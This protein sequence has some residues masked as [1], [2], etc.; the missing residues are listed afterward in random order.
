MPAV[1]QALFVDGVPRGFIGRRYS[2]DPELSVVERPGSTAM[3]RFGSAGLGD[4]I[5]IDLDTGHVIE[6]VNARVPVEVFVNST[7]QQ[8]SRTVESMIDRFPYYDSD[9]DGDELDAVSHELLE[10]IRR[11]DPPAAI[12]DRYWSTFIDD[13]GIG[14]LTT[15]AVAK[16]YRARRGN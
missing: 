12:P 11:I 5:A 8:F 15:E 10:L 13:V 14:D 1:E 7:I 16:I 9:E 6:L 2:A 4:A 3:L